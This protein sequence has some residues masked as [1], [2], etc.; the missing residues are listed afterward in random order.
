MPNDEAARI[1][2]GL[3]KD[4]E[5]LVRLGED[6]CALLRSQAAL[7]QFEEFVCSSGPDAGVFARLLV[8]AWS[9]DSLR[10]NLAAEAGSGQAG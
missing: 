3:A 1:G 8:R 10:R 4:C 6:R 9:G 5:G 7:I 2:V